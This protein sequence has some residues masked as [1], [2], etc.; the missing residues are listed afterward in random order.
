MRF[1]IRTSLRQIRANIY[2]N[3]IVRSKLAVWLAIEEGVFSV[4]FHFVY[5][6]ILLTWVGSKIKKKSWRYIELFFARVYWEIP[7]VIVFRIKFCTMVKH[8]SAIG[9]LELSASLTSD[10]DLD[11]IRLTLFL[12]CW[13]NGSFD[14]WLWNGFLQLAL[15]IKP[16]NTTAVFFP[17]FFQD[18]ILK[19]MRFKENRYRT[20]HFAIRAILVFAC[21]LTRTS[22]VR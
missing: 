7:V 16:N 15:R 13:Q 17:F 22:L 11:Q 18:I 12:I 3:C 6:V 21:N 2:L 9:V 4:E 14:S 1:A 5:E 10:L 20:H 19:M 8:S